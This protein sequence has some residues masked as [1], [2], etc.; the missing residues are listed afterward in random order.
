MLCAHASGLPVLLAQDIAYVYRLLQE[1][2]LRSW[3][4]H[5]T[6]Q[7]LQVLAPKTMRVN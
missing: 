1:D 4:L 2:L 7:S 6:S 5:A 3:A